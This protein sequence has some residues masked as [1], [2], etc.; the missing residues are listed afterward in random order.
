MRATLSLLF[1][2]VAVATWATVA[3][4]G[5]VQ[6]GLITHTDEEVVPG[7][8]GLH[9][10]HGNRAIQVPQARV[11]CAFQGN[12]RREFILLARI[13]VC[14]NDGDFYRVVWLIVMRHGPKEHSITV[15]TLVYI[16]QKVLHRSGRTFCIQ[17][18]LEIA[19][20]GLN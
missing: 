18:E 8:I 16:V 2:L 6:L 3:A 4:A 15:K 11:A 5:E 19:D 17:L 9:A 12:R 20:V 14:L 1:V 10:C 13:G 7:R